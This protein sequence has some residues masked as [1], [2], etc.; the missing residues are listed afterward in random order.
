MRRTAIAIVIAVAGAVSGACS[1][2][3]DGPRLPPVQAAASPATAHALVDQL[4]RHL[5]S[6]RSGV[7]TEV[8]VAV[9]LDSWTDKVHTADM[10]RDITP[11]IR[12]HMLMVAVVVKDLVAPAADARARADA[13]AAVKKWSRSI[14]KAPAVTA[15]TAAEVGPALEVEIV[16]LHMMIDGVPVTSDQRGQYEHRAAFP[17]PS[18]N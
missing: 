16:N 11:D 12:D 4:W 8:G 9:W 2:S 17:P 18:A 5:D 7:D 6:Y 3:S 1:G 14:Y 15:V 13:V 10:S